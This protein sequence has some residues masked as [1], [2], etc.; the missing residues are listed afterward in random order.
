[1]AVLAPATQS[2][3]AE[4][5]A[6]LTD[7]RP[8]VQSQPRDVAA[9]TG[10]SRPALA[11]ETSGT[12]SVVLKASVAET[13]TQPL[14]NSAGLREVKAVIGESLDFDNFIVYC[15]PPATPRFDIRLPNSLIPPELRAYGRP[16]F[17]SIDSQDGYKRPVIKPR[18]VTQP[19]DETKDIKEIDRWIASI[20]C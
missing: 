19:L 8:A 20:E 15:Y 6:G 2:G 12:G 17:V 5:A 4:E 16:V 10:L 13:P 3:L 14:I 11:T 18:E 1:M 7:F 9:I